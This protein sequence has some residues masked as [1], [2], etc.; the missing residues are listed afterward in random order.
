VGALLVVVGVAAGVTI[1]VLTVFAFGKVDA[2]V[3]NDGIPHLVTVGTHGERATWAHPGQGARCT[4]VD[5]STG[6]PLTTTP[7]AGSATKSTNGVK[8]Q[9]FATFD[10]GRTGRLDVTCASDRGPIQIG[11]A[12]KLTQFVG[13]IF[14]TIL[15]P[16][17][18][19]GAGLAVLVVTTVLTV[20]GRPREPVPS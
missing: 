18:L 5:T 4:I 7:Y 1:G 6:N 8:W 10:A 11:P 14:A 12:P 3:P 15:I 17:F 19:G 2:T 16:L 20:I 13:G 9:V